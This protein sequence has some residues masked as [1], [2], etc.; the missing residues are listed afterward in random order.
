M[1][2]L[3]AN[4]EVFDSNGRVYKAK[5]TKLSRAID[6][7]NHILP[8]KVDDGIKIVAEGIE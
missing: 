3:Y 2:K 6:E 5:N 7:M 8:A 4:I 1:A